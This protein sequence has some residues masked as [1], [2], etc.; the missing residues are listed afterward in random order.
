VKE[1]KIGNHKE[2]IGQLK[3]MEKQK[4]NRVK[5]EKT[6]HSTCGTPGRWLG[7]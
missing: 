4:G 2:G 5:K 6:L 1:I 7:L 3:G